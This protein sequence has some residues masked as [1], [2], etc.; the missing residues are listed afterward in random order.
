MKTGILLLENGSAGGGSFEAIRQI[1]GHLNPDR[2]RLVVSFVNETPL[3]Q[4]LRARAVQTYLL[5]DPLYSV[6]RS[7]NGKRAILRAHRAVDRWFPSGGVGFERMVHATIIR[8]LRRFVEQNRIEILH[9]NN[10]GLRDFYGVLLAMEL[11]IPCISFLR[12]VHT[13][14]VTQQKVTFLNQ[15]V[16][17]FIANSE[18]TR[19]HWVDLGLDAKKITTLHN[20]IEAGE[21]EALDLHREWGVSSRFIIGSI[22]R[23][24]HTH[25]DSKGQS[26]LLRAFRYVLQE[27]PDSTLFL[28]GDGGDRSTLVELSRELKVNHAVIFT[29][30]DPRAKAI[31]AALDVLVV[32]SFRES[33][34]RT[35]LEGMRAGTPLVGVRS[36]GIPEVVEDGVNGL[37]VEFND[38]RALSLAIFSGLTAYGAAPGRR[39]MRGAGVFGFIGAAIIIFT[40]STNLVTA[41]VTL[42]VFGGALTALLLVTNRMLVKAREHAS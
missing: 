18:F 8:K 32:P 33:F 25:L 16:S 6:K 14:Q 31:I 2:F 40:Y 3:L 27:E 5:E 21:V 20:A 34:G 10:H 24:E 26:F 41:G 1:A 42:I 11:Q 28:V 38:E 39:W 30:Y 22:G 7:V 15:N 36:G 4:M 17:C 13:E 35:L 12:S 23:L 37:L 9:L 19:Q 29:G